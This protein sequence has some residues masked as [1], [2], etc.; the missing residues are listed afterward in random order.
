MAGSDRSNR[1][2]SFGAAADAYERGRPSYPTAVVDWLMPTGARCVVD[3]GAGTG[4][5]TRLLPRRAERVIAIEPSAPMIDK[6]RAISPDVDAREGNAK[7]IPV[8]TDSADAVLCAQA[9]HWVDPATASHE[10][11]RVLRPGGMLGLV[12]NF[13]YRNVRWVADLD[14]DQFRDLVLSRSFM[15]TSDETRRLEALQRILA[16]NR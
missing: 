8:E 10:V 16:L 4:K 2:L 6:L 12:W 11:G 15:I 13:R 3:L 14:R 1:A 9:W 5:L 7:A